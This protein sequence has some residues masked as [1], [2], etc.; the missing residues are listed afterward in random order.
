VADLGAF[1]TDSS[2]PTAAS[3]PLQTLLAAEVEELSAELQA[4]FAA[5][6]EEVF[7]PLR[8]LVA[9]VHVWTD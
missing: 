8:D 6:L 9:T 7:Q 2:L 1:A 5:H 3:G 4:L